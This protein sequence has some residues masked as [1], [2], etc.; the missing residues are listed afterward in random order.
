MATALSV[1]VCTT[2]TGCPQG[3]VFLLLARRKE[4]VEVE[5]QPLHRV[6]G[7]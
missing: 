5:E 1:S 3:R 7:R 6:F 4:G 2:M